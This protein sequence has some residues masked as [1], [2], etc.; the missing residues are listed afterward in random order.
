V[1]FTGSTE[2]GRRIIKAAAGNLKKVTLELGGKSPVVV[3]DDADLETTVAG[4]S[5]G[6]FML[7][8]QIC[9]AGSRLFVQRKRFEDVVAGIVANAKGLKVGNGFDPSVQMGP[10]ISAT[11][12]ERVTQLISSGL[13]QGATVATGGSRFGGEGY[14][15]Q[16][17]VITGAPLGARVVKEEIFGPVI[18]ASSFDDVDELAGIANDTEYGLAGA[19]WTRDVSKAHLMAKRIRVGTFWINCQMMSDLS[20]P[21]GGYKQSG[22][23]REHGWDGLDAYLQM[24]SVFTQL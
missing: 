15:V 14:F 2:V 24:K 13:S 17:T 18:V 11:Q 16:P 23:G 10:L 9:Q 19:V 21:Y 4:V 7:T 3:F 8:G 20:L 5:A 22:W 6:V 1:A 12:L